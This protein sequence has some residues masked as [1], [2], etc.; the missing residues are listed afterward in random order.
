MLLISERLNLGSLAPKRLMYTSLKSSQSNKALCL[1][2]LDKSIL[3]LLHNASKELD[4]P[5]NLFLATSRESTT[6]F[7]L[8][9]FLY[10]R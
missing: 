6:S 10:R 5:G 8:I 7:W 2:L 9:I 1:V 3:N 4:D